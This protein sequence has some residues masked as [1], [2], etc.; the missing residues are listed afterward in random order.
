[1]L[2]FIKCLLISIFRQRNTYGGVLFQE[3][4]SASRHLFSIYLVS[5]GKTFFDM[6]YLHSL[7]EFYERIGRQRNENQ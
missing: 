1:M 4:L 2:C 6:L 5:D 3:F 7:D